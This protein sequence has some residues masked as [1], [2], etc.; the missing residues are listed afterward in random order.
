MP[1]AKPQASQVPRYQLTEKCYLN[2]RLYDPDEMPLD[3]AAEPNDEGV[4]P[5][6]ALVIS[7]KGVPAP[8]M[9]PVNDA[10]KAMCEKHKERMAAS[11]NPIDALTVVGV[12]PA[13]A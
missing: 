5:R 1:E 8:Y 9:I 7:F 3:T 6:K 2:E 4:Q 12:A 13:A 10:A 11:V